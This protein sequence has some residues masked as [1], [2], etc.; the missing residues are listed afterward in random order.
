MPVR[1]LRSSVLKWPDRES[2]DQAV[3]RWA[4]AVVQDRDDVLAIAYLGSY[5][6]GDWGVGSDL[7][8][9]VLIAGSELP[10]HRRAIEFDTRALPVPADVFV[11]TME[12]WRVMQREGR[13][14]YRTVD[15]DAVW[16]YRRDDAPG[17]D[18]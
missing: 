1:S 15:D 7:D 13:R 6:R 17:G 2:V 14:F 11:Y 9:L 4:A 12:E 18:A 8:L 3:R 5:A 10:C 16:V